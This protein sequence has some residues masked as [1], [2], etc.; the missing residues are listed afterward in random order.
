MLKLAQVPNNAGEYPLSNNEKPVPPKVLHMPTW[1]NN[2][3]ATVDSD[4]LEMRQD[5]EEAKQYL[6]FRAKLEQ[7]PDAVIVEGK[8]RESDVEDDE[9]Q[10]QQIEAPE[11]DDEP[12]QQLRSGNPLIDMIHFLLEITS[13]FDYIGDIIVLLALVGE[14]PAWATLS[15]YFMLSPFYISYIPLI[16]F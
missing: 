11:E 16:N 3:M 1:N 15:I 13:T 8:P 9:E 12:R 2:A 10:E 6:E 5:S 4:I 7:H 14:H